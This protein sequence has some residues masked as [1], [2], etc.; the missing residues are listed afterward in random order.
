MTP[1]LAVLFPVRNGA[2]TLRRSLDSL[3]A[4]SWRHFR[5]IAVDDGSTDDTLRI[6]TLTK[7]RWAAEVEARPGPSLTIV[8]LSPGQGIARALQA[9][10]AEVQGEEFLARQDADDSS[11]PHRFERQID[12]LTAH[13]GLGLSATGIETLSAAGTTEGWRSYEAWLSSCNTPEEIARGL[14]VEC[15]LP[16]PT[17]MMRREAYERAGGYRDVPWP[18]DYDLWL[19]MLRLG[20][21]MAKLP[22]VLYQ[23]QDHAG[24]ASRTLPAYT[25]Q[26]FLACRAHHLSRFLSESPHHRGRPIII[27]GAGRDGRRAAKALTREGVPVHAF[28]DIDPAKIGRRAYGRPILSA[29]TFLTGGLDAASPVELVSSQ[30]PSPVILAAVGTRGAR[31]LIRARLLSTGRREGSDFICVA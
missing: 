9:A 25:P 5:V 3:Q 10:A 20:I 13:P 6:L 17:V 7:D 29:E 15:P 31:A 24:R 30:Q 26:S 21:V 27:W 22:D 2:A 28:L 8:R 16:H 12:H 11:L 4:Q 14:W 1:C 19:R 23:W 18:E